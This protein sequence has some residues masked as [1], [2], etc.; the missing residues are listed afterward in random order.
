MIEPLRISFELSCSAEHAFETW[1]AKIG[2]WWPRSHTT[3]G[4]PQ[5][6][7]VL[8][9]GMGGR[10]FERTGDGREIDWGQITVWEPPRRLAYLWH[11]RQ[12]RANAT[13]VHVQFVTVDSL[14]T[15]I[16]IEHGGWDRLGDAGQDWRN[17]N[18]G[19]WGGMLPHFIEAATGEPAHGIQISGI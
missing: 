15:R 2:T 13:D 1:T 16:E 17:R 9:P 3:S 10:I 11:I 12:E 18:R 8:E 14:R 6:R 19:G 4:D 7:V 5:A